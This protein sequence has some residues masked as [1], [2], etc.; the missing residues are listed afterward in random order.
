MFNSIFDEL[1]EVKYFTEID[2]RFPES[3]DVKYFNF[4][5][6]PSKKICVVCFIESPLK[7]MKNVFYFVL[8][9]L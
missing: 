7:V 2:N 3:Y 8:K 5:L 1:K 9:A 4:E 6:S